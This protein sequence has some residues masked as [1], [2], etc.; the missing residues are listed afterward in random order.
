M[1]LGGPLGLS[2]GEAA[3]LLALAL[4]PFVVILILL[5]VGG[6]SVGGRWW[7]SLTALALGIATAVVLRRCFRVEGGSA[8]MLGA[9]VALVLSTGV[10]VALGPS[11][12]DGQA[13]R[14]PRP[15]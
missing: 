4:L 7:T 3:L 15:G 14:P 6:R 1:I 13:T 5:V 11:R 10:R 8:V 9:L 2:G 12:R